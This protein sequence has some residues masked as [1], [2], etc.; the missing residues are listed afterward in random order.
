MWPQVRPQTSKMH[1]E[2]GGDSSKLA[3]ALGGSSDAIALGGIEG[4]LAQIG[5]AVMGETEHVLPWPV[6]RPPMHYYT[7]LIHKLNYP[8]HIQLR[9]A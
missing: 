6:S 9:L 2:V 4:A 5:D 1:V 3:T 8:L 7:S